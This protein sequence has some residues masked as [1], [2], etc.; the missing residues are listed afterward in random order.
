MHVKVFPTSL[1][2]HIEAYGSKSLSHRY[3]ICASLSKEPSTIVGLSESEDVTATI[4]ALEAFDVKIEN[5]QVKNDDPKVVFHHIDAKESGSTLRF[6]IPYAMLFH[7]EITIDGSESLRK[8]PIDAYQD[9]FRNKAVKFKS[10]K[11]S[12]LPIEVKGKLKGGYYKIRGDISSQFISGMMMVLP[13]LKSDSVIEIEGD[14]VSK[15]YIDLTIDVLKQFG[16][17]IIEVLPF[18]YIKKN[19]TYHPVHIKVEGDYS[20]AANFMV[21]GCLG[22]EIKISNLNPTSIQGDKKIIDILKEMGANIQWEGLDLVVKH[23]KLKGTQIDLKDIPDLGPIL[24]VAAAFSKG[25]TVFTNYER[26]RLKESDRVHAM[27][28]ALLSLGVEFKINKN[29]IRI[30][31]KD[32]ILGGLTL[33]GCSDHRIVMALSVLSCYTEAPNM[34]SDFKAISKSYPKFFDDLKSSKGVFNYETE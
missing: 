34:I 3:L 21:A 13:T 26:L 18:Y 22:N 14:L 32:M 25:E 12:G 19:Q 6:M 4:K 8:R 33:D 31:G 11:G 2:G 27:E 23:S 29:E 15:P 5:H 1:H 28:K 20:H 7:E 16:V 10:L 30:K 24:F 17:E 9:V